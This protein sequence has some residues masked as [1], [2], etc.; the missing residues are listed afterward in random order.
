VNEPT[1]SF[2]G[3][4]SLA[5]TVFCRTISDGV[6][7][8]QVLR[9]KRN[10]EPE[11]RRMQAPTT[12]QPRAFK[13]APP[14]SAMQLLGL[15]QQEGRFIDFVEEEVAGFS[16]AA[17]G[18]AARVIHEGCRRVVHDHFTI[19]PIRN[20]LEGSRVTV[21]AGFDPSAVRLTGRVI[22]KPPFTGCLIHRG[23]R[24]A[25]AKLPKV[26]EGHDTR[27]LASAEV[28]L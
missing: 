19:V 21:D 28:E 16:D 12:P 14:D 7:A 20:E 27:V 25:E 17:I 6:F 11:L 15:L 5:F 3:R 10:Q 1:L 9:L 26:S 8:I 23:W 4:L 24:V 2:F 22:G 18:A 13:E